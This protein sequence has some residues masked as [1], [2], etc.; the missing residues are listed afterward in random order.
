MDDAAAAM[1]QERQDNLGVHEQYDAVV[2]A[3]GTQHSSMLLEEEERDDTSFHT[4]EAPLVEE[5]KASCG[6]TAEGGEQDEDMGEDSNL[7]GAHD[8]C[9]GAGRDE[10][11]IP[12]AG[13]AEVAQQAPVLVLLPSILELSLMMDYVPHSSDSHRCGVAA[14]ERLGEDNVAMVV[15]M[16]LEEEEKDLLQSSLDTA[17][18]QLVASLVPILEQHVAHQGGARI[19]ECP[20][21]ADP[22]L[23]SLVK[24][25]HCDFLKNLK[26]CEN[27]AVLLVMS[28]PWF[29]SRQQSHV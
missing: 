20:P 19:V 14:E 22:S 13:E 12:W 18:Q 9:T 10:E 25:L 11:R 2:V 8:A 17:S 7:V 6:D 3:D 29:V 28:L 5:D 21:F 4:E 15:G 27:D 23:H 26:L 16:L 24:I 1:D